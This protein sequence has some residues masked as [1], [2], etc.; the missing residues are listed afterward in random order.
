MLRDYRAARA[1]VAATIREHGSTEAW[2][3]SA[4][5]RGEGAIHKD[6]TTLSLREPVRE[7]ELEHDHSG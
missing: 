2:C 4:A 7:V 1:Q 3:A 5:A 6:L